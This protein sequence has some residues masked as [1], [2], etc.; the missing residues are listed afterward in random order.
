M[1]DGAGSVNDG[2]DATDVCN[3]TLFS[4]AG[5]PADVDDSV[6]SPLGREGTDVDDRRDLVTLLGG[7]AAADVV[8]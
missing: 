2:E 6:G 3:S 1:A 8:V 7:E 5:E 4:R